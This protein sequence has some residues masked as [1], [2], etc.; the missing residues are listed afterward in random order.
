MKARRRAPPGEV[1]I[2]GGAWRGRKIAVPDAPGL[3][4]T[5]D[6]VRETLFNWLAPVLPGMRC[7]DLFA[8]S[9]ALGFEAA[10]RGASRVV[11]VERDRATFRALLASRAALGAGAVELRRADAIEFLRTPADRYDVVFVDPPFT[12]G[13]L[14]RLWALLPQHMEPG[15][16]VYCESAARPSAPEG[17]ETWRE[18]RAGRV[19]YQLLKRAPA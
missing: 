6:R 10:S 11:M 15:A 9:G 8:G 2:I 17:W 16:L 4:P 5:G 18:G 1:R 14:P 7:L 12:A 3:R 19:V 13:Y